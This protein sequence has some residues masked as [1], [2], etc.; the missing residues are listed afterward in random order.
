MQAK[1]TQAEVLQSIF[2]LMRMRRELSLDASSGDIG[3]MLWLADRSPVNARTMCLADP[4]GVVDE[5]VRDITRVA[6]IFEL[7]DGPAEVSRTL[8]P[9]GAG[10]RAALSNDTDL[11]VSI[12]VAIQRYVEN[13]DVR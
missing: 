12:R 7:F 11:R 6:D 10:L 8:N 3:M 1:Y 4:A 5:V 2:G 13:P 9:L